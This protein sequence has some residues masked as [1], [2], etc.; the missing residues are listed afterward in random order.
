MM[1]DLFCRRIRRSI[2]HSAF[3]IQAIALF[4]QHAAD[5]ASAKYPYAFVHHLQVDMSVEM[6]GLLEMHEIAA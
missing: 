4:E 2:Q 1:R 3:D 6:I 5:M